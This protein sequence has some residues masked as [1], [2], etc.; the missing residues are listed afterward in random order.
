MSQNRVVTGLSERYESAKEAVRILER[1][2][3]VTKQIVALLPPG[4]TPEEILKTL[5][6][7][8]DDSI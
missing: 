7:T 4:R 6:G 3:E 8:Y 5:D 1:R 2:I